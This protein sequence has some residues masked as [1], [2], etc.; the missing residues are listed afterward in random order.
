MLGLRLDEGVLFADTTG[1]I[2][3]SALDRLVA[4]DLV[5]VSPAN[6]APPALFL[7]DRGRR[8]GDGV[9]AELLA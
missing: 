5:R 7:T 2:D 3:A 8:L 9:T 1:A 6:G 4:A